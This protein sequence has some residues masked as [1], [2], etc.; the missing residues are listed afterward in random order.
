MK[1]YVYTKID[2]IEG[3]GFH[4]L[5]LYRYLR[6]NYEELKSRD[7]FRNIVFEAMNNTSH[8]SWTE[9]E[10]YIGIDKNEVEISEIEFLALR[11]QMELLS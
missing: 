11:V 3:D 2:R 7:V 1:K 5:G 9:V 4:F 8:T 10:E 6:E